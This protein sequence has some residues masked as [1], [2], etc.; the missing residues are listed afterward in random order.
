[1]DSRDANLVIRD[2][3]FV[4]W[5][6]GIVFL[7]AGVFTARTLQQGASL[8][9]DGLT[10]AFLVV[11]VVLLLTAG[12]FTIT[13]D[14]ATQTLTLDKRSL[15]GKST[16]GIP[17]SQI[18]AIDLESQPSLSIDSNAP[19]YRV[20]ATLTDGQTVPF[21]SAYTSG[22]AAKLKEIGKLRSFVGVGGPRAVAGAVTMGSQVVQAQFQVHGDGTTRGQRGE[23]NAL[24]PH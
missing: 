2:R 24:D 4:S 9:K 15:L 14:R 8:V 23:H 12:T 16:R 22:S 20:V 1:M 6:L 19:T 17:F 10:L 5:L 13:A 7:A 11:A 3:P 18:A 21:R